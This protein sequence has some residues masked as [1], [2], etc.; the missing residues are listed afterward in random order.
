MK[1]HNFY[2]N[3]LSVVTFVNANILFPLLCF[4][5]FVEYIRIK[6]KCILRLKQYERGWNTAAVDELF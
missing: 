1:K 5:L 6:T 3:I 2:C 4:G